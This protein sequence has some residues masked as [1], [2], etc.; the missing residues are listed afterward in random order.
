MECFFFVIR[1]SS[2]TVKPIFSE[3]SNE[4][5]PSNQRTFFFRTVPYLALVNVYV[6]MGH[7][8]CSDTLQLF[9][10]ALDNDFELEKNHF[11]LLRLP[12]FS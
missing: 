12:K 11:I 3:H 10:S 5:T 1:Y 8:S 4:R 2:D 6:T 9:N 7:L